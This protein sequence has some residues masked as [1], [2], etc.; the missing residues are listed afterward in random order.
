MHGLYGLR[1]FAES[2]YSRRLDF[3]LIDHFYFSLFI[4]LYTPT[5][6]DE[7]LCYAKTFA[8]LAFFEYAMRRAAPNHQSKRQWHWLYGMRYEYI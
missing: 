1:R 3:V 6:C 5:A 2:T 4:R 7:F 8:P